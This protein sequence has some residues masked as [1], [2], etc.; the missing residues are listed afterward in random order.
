MDSLAKYFG[1]NS[2]VRQA[3][4]DRPKT[5]EELRKEGLALAK[6]LSKET[7]EKRGL[8]LLRAVGHD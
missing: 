6:K 5:Y 3:E 2:E 7:G 4:E 1:F 8:A